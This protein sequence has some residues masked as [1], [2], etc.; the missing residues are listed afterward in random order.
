[1]LNYSVWFVSI[2]LLFHSFALFLWS[3]FVGL[4]SIPAAMPFPPSRSALPSLPFLLCPIPN[5]C[6]ILSNGVLICVWFR[7]GCLGNQKYLQTPS[8]TDWMILGSSL[9]SHSNSCFNSCFNCCPLLFLLHS[10]ALVWLQSSFYLTQLN[11]PAEADVTLSSLAMEQCL[12]DSR[13]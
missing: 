8:C 5:T 1:M 13:G 12:N 7:Q 3:H 9:R 10:L 6:I 2:C 4:S 11:S